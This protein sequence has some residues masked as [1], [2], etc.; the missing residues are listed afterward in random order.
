MDIASIF[1]V[2]VWCPKALTA[3]AKPFCPQME[4]SGT[5]GLPSKSAPSGILGSTAKPLVQAALN[6]QQAKVAKAPVGAGRRFGALTHLGMQRVTGDG[7]C[8]ALATPKETSN[9]L[10]PASSV[11]ASSASFARNHVTLVSRI[12][13]EICIDVV[14]QHQRAFRLQVLQMKFT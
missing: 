3:S 8:V 2:A 7:L 14:V 12:F 9:R 5:Q 13:R 4:A 1:R 6:M 11:Q 10:S